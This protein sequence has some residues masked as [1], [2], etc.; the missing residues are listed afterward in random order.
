MFA[1]RENNEEKE[2]QSRRSNPYPP[3]PVHVPHPFP[4]EFFLRAPPIV[5]RLFITAIG[6]FIDHIFIRSKKKKKEKKEGDPTSPT[7]NLAAR[8]ESGEE[9]GGGRAGLTRSISSVR[10]SDSVQAHNF[11]FDY[12]N[13]VRKSS[14]CSLIFNGRRS[15]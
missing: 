4:F 15:G 1:V 3:L 8:I 2:F 14:C 11:M 9:G 10:G 12:R 13:A 7:Y 5:Q 6:T